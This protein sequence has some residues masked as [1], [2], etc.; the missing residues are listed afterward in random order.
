MP[1]KYLF[2]FNTFSTFFPFCA[3]VK[4][5]IF[6]HNL[7]EQNF[8]TDLFTDF[9]MSQKICSQKLA[10]KKFHPSYLISES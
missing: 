9:G 7:I 3:D 4:F 6:F 2:S 10:S 8:I 5:K 1:I